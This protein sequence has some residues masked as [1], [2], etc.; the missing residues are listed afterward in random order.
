MLLI[1]VT[2]FCSRII[3]LTT[4]PVVFT[5]TV[6]TALA[7]GRLYIGDGVG[8]KG[9][10]GGEGRDQEKGKGREGEENGGHGW[11]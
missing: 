6:L 1:A 3:C 11:E 7:Q 5:A 10:Q 2:A 4:V 8:R 9:G